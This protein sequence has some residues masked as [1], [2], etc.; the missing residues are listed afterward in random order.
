MDVNVA[1]KYQANLVG[2]VG[3]VYQQIDFIAMLDMPD[4]TP[5]EHLIE[6]TFQVTCAVIAALGKL[7][8][9]LFALDPFAKPHLFIFKADTSAT[10]GK[11][12]GARLAIITSVT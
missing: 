7:F 4:R 8:D 1:I 6:I 9:G 11:I 10:V 5:R 12:T 3:A 2:K